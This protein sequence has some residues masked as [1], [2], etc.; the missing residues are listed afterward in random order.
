MCSAPCPE[1]EFTRLEFVNDRA[2]GEL[3]GGNRGGS[4][5]KPYNLRSAL[6]ASDS[7]CAVWLEGLLEVEG[8]G[9]GTIIVEML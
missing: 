1:T 5:E 6:A 4:A 7:G 8:K 3:W 9:G 2:A